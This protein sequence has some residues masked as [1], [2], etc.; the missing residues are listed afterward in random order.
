MIIVDL[1]GLM[2]NDNIWMSLAKL[3]FVDTSIQKKTNI[4]TNAKYYTWYHIS[5]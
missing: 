4:W 5:N 2:V 1:L 3:L